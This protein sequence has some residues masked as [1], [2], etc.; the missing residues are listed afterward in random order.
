MPWVFDNEISYI[1]H[2]ASEKDAWKNET[3]AECTL[4]DGT[5]VEVLKTGSVD[6]LEK[7]TVKLG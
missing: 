3:I 5:A 1:K 2:R 7:G 4:A 6:K